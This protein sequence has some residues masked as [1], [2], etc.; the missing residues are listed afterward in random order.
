M[1]L[2]DQQNIDAKPQ[3]SACKRAG[4]RGASRI[5]QCR[6]RTLGVKAVRWHCYDSDAQFGCLTGDEF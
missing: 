1:S 5:L 2:A 3:G 4:F 6:L